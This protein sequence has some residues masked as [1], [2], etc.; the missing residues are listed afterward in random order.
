MSEENAIDEAIYGEDELGYFSQGNNSSDLSVDIDGYIICPQ[1]FKPIK[2]IN[3][4]RCVE[5]SWSFDKQGYKYHEDGVPGS[6][7]RTC[8]ECSVSLEE[9][10]IGLFLSYTE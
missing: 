10:N 4:E 2:T 6:S 1:C 3:E 5:L 9:Y 7:G 8:G